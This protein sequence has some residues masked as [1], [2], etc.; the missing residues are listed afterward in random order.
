MKNINDLNHTSDSIRNTYNETKKN[1]LPNSQQY[2]SYNYKQGTDKT[3]KPGRWIDSL[4]VK[5]VTDSLKKE[6]LTNAKS[7]AAS[8][9]SYVKSNA[10]YLQAKIKDA[11]KYELE[12]HHKY[13]QALSCLVMFL[14]GAPLGAIIKK[15]GFGVP[16]LVSVLFFILLYVLI[17]QGDKWVKEGLV[18]V[19][20]GAWLANTV[21]F[22]AGMY[23]IDRARSDSRLFD[24][25]VYQMRIKRIKSFFASRFGKTPL[26][27][28]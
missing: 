12:K 18:I 21:L 26:I 5:P 23:F 20:V 27:N 6:I 2:F 10:E 3:L 9:Q 14:I 8:M 22:L 28:Q 24:K 11:S 7:S 4:L 13:T 1:L 25:D 17:N 15:G 16:V 19:P